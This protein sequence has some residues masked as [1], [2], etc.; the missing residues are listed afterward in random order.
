MDPFIKQLTEEKKR[1]NSLIEDFLASPNY[2]EWGEKIKPTEKQEKKIYDYWSAI[3]DD[4]F[5]D[6]KS[7][8]G[9]RDEL[10]AK[11]LEKI[12]EGMAMIKLAP[13]FFEESYQNYKQMS[14][15][16]NPKILKF[17]KDY[18]KY[19]KTIKKG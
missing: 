6:F 3:T 16:T 11:G 1:Q 5:L 15:V 13:Q 7:Y 14:G 2:K 12:A 9:G 10:I 17:M 18:E 19:T 4:N 8:L